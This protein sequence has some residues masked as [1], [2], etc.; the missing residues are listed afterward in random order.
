MRLIR[1]FGAF[2][3][4]VFLDQFE[5]FFVR[6]AD[7]KRREF[8]AAF[9]HCLQHSEAKDLCFVLA[10]RREFLGQLTTEFE[11]Q[12]PEFLNEAYRINLLPL[13]KAEARE[14]VLRP[15]D[16]TTLRIQY[17]EDFVDDVLL[18]GL[19]EQTGGGASI[20][21][22]HLQIVCNQLFE[23]AR[24]RLQTRN[25]VLIN[26]A[27]YDELGGAENILNTYLDK[28][29]E[30]VAQDPRRI[31]V[32]HSILKTM[33]DAGANTRSFV[34]IE[35]FRRALPDV[36]EAEILKLIEKLLDRRVVEERKPAYSLSHE[37][38]VGKVKEWF[39]PRELERKRAEE[40]LNRGMM[41]WKNSGALLNRGQVERIRK[42]LPDLTEEEHELLQASEKNYLEEEQKEASRTKLRKLSLYGAAAFAVVVMIFGAHFLF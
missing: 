40:T 42:W 26:R 2:P 34:A 14:A 30:D 13:S 15:L 17:D 7:D 19:A 20:D 16:N 5:R 4:V 39:D 28:V 32:V 27:L 38:M 41:E 23:A 12:I 1:S 21:P 6:V 33:I 24:Q 9:N 29:V 37:H 18:V 11:E 3:I 31:T 36:N 35:G 25:S 22:P 8:I 10:F